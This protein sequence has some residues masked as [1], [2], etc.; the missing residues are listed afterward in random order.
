MERTTGAPDTARFFFARPADAHD[1]AALAQLRAA[2]LFGE[3]VMSL[4]A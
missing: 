2:S 4:S 3:A 1:A